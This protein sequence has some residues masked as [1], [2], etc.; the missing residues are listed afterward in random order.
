VDDEPSIRLLCRVNLEL[1]GYDVREAATLAEARA[2]LEADAPAVVLLDLHVGR[3]RG[4]TL[5]EE[6][7]LREPR[8]AVALVTGSVEIE[9]GQGDAG[10]DAVIVKPFTIDLLTSTV[11]ALAAGEQPR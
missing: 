3:E 2:A 8:I 5:L 1:E 9:Q 11:R 7:R 4:V 10:A 6:I